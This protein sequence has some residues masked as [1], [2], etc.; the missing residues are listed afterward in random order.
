M[1]HFTDI[2]KTIISQLPIIL[3]LLF[4]YWTFGSNQLSYKDVMNQMN[5]RDSIISQMIDAQGRLVTTHTNR[6]YSPYVIQNSNDPEMVELRKELAN[7]GIK[8]SDLRSAVDIQTKASG[9]G[10]TTIVY[11]RDTIN[12]ADTYQFADTTKFMKIN[13]Q[14]DLTNNKLDYKYTYTGNYSLYSYEYRK[15]FWKRPEM[16]IKLVSDD[17]SNEISMKTFTVKPPR[18]I[19]SIG[20]GIGASF[21]YADGKFGVA[22]AITI[23]VFKPIYTFRTKN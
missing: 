18:E 13:G 1:T 12:N 23:G 2:L 7:L 19:V 22:P 11:V 9:S 8:V 10:S 5:Q 6:Q 4:L 16:Q 20:V 14:V 3:I 15:K 21:Y 17:P